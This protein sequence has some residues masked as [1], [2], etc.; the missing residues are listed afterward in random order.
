VATEFT[1]RPQHGRTAAHEGALGIGTGAPFRQDWQPRRIL[2]MPA[3]GVVAAT[4][5]RGPSGSVVDGRTAYVSASCRVTQHPAPLPTTDE[6]PLTMGDRV[7]PISI[8]ELFARAAELEELEMIRTQV[9]FQVFYQTQ[10]FDSIR[11]Q[12]QR[13]ADSA[14]DSDSDVGEAAVAAAEMQEIELQKRRTLSPLQKILKKLDARSLTASQELARLVNAIPPT[15]PAPCTLGHAPLTHSSLA[16]SAYARDSLLRA[17]KHAARDYVGPLL[18]L[19]LRLLPTAALADAACATPEFFAEVCTAIPRPPA[20]APCNPAAPDVCLPD[21]ALIGM[22]Q[23][24][25]FHLPAHEL[26]FVAGSPV[27]ASLVAAICKNAAASFQTHMAK[28]DAAR[29]RRPTDDLQHQLD[30]VALAEKQAQAA[31]DVFSTPVPLL[32]AK[33][34]QSY[35]AQTVGQLPSATTADA[36]ASLWNLMMALHELF[37]PEHRDVAAQMHLTLLQTAPA[38]SLLGQLSQ[39]AI[40][41]LKTL[42]AGQ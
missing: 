11:A 20:S 16:A 15:S 41:D 14:G 2:D 38:S 7:A 39:A 9:E 35:A 23:A 37:T 30:S 13:I 28:A 40:N 21:D 17:I 42:Q 10:Y 4:A 5:C 27:A 12:A 29:I 3:P 34:V 8:D 1:G 22:L 36:S 26:L 19:L 25:I 33:L 6:H 18:L 24:L 32:Y 31:L